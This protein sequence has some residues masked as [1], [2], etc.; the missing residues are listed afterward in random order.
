MLEVKNYGEESTD[1][2]IASLLY[3]ELMAKKCNMLIATNL[4]VDMDR[5]LELEGYL[6][7]MR[8]EALKIKEVLDF[9]NVVI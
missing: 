1:T 5:V 3:L 9:R 7:T 6:E 4:Y 2:L 8:E